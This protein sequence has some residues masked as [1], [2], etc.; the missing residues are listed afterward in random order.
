MRCLLN[1]LPIM[2]K[3]LLSIFL[4]ILPC[5]AFSQTITVRN[6]NTL[7]PLELVSIV[8]ATTQNFA[9]TD[10]KGNADITSLKGAQTLTFILIGFE[11]LALSKKEL[12]LS[13][14]NIVL[15]PSSFP[16]DEV[17][18]STTRWEQKVTDVPNKITVIKAN[19]VKVQQPQTTADLLGGS[20][21]VFIQK[22]QM[23]GGSPMI[24]GFA[25][26]RVLITIDG[27]RMNNAIFRSGNLQNVIAIDPFSLD[28][29][30]IIYGP[31]SVIY[32]SDALGGVMNFSTSTPRLSGTSKPTINGTAST[33][34]SSASNESTSHFDLNLGFKKIAF[35]T[36]ATYSQFDD[37]KMGSNGPDEYL[38][39]EYVEHINGIDSVVSNADG[40]LQKFTGYNQLNLM[41]KVFFKP[42]REWTFTYGGHYSKTSDVPRYDRLIE[43]QEG[44]LKSAEWYYGPQEWQMHTI[45]AS[46]K[47]HT[48]LS[49]HMQITGAWQRFKESRNDRRFGNPILRHRYEEVQVASL[50]VDLEKKLTDKHHLYYGAELVSNLVGSSAENE[51]IETGEL[52]P[53]S[54]RYPDGATWNSGAVYATWTFNPTEKLTTQAGIRYSYIDIQAEFD[55]SFF[56]LPISSISTNPQALNGSLGASY[57]P[58][59]N[60]IFKANASTGFR[61]PNI[62]DIAKVFDSEPGT[63]V[64]PNA[65]LK[66][67]YAW[68]G[69][70]GLIKTIKERIRLD[71][72][73]F[74]T[75]L[76]DALVRRPY[77]INGQD[78]LIYDGELS[79]VQS[80]QNAAQAT[81][82]GIQ[83]GLDVRFS[84]SITLSSKWSF[85]KGEE[86]L[87]DGSISALRHAAPTFG[88]IG[89]TYNKLR[90]RVDLNWKYNGEI[91]HN[92]LALTERDKPILYAQDTNGDPYSP[93]WQTFNLNLL[94]RASDQI[95]LT[96]GVE[97]ITDQRYRTYSSGI[98]AAGRNFLVAGVFKF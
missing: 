25:A 88:L 5:F 2:T 64:V 73:G 4:L 43:H 49:D 86:E 91:D 82:Y 26:N 79:Q 75:F 83:A 24:R 72:A 71:I 85:Q 69:E 16:L 33:R 23:G 15:S 17:V 95:S 90:F 38:R 7:E 34:Y 60:W 47:K 65:D 21:Y 9:L 1:Q 53:L 76:Q 48:T 20:G 54:T 46:Q 74:Y 81:V 3:K 11:R 94:F 68:S 77:E 92:N 44:V 8:D 62:D 61:A 42:N 56:P 27:V 37:L 14:F 78:S 67:E 50:N 87:D 45:S 58:G 39:T 19:D 22:S 51:N 41:Q 52:S 35:T 63:V 28:R 97:N 12:Q 57:R 84:S 13:N 6:A 36:S 70:L 80:I 93:S 40:R 32:G 96:A 66:P 18:I 55:S 31:G 29:T 30:E 59:N 10:A 89:L 98:T